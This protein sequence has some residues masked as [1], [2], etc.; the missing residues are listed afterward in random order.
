MKKGRKERGREGGRPQRRA[1]VKEEKQ[2]QRSWSQNSGSTKLGKSNNPSKSWLSHLKWS[3]ETKT[4]LPR[5][6][7]YIMKMNHC[8]DNV[9]HSKCSI[10]VNY[11]LI[12]TKKSMSRENRKR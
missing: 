1:G 11:Y 6:N 8:S 3:W 5:T 10:N 4:Q 9:I 12:I 7:M 2:E